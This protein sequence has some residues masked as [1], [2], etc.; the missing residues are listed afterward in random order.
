[1]VDRSSLRL[2]AFVLQAI[3]STFFGLLFHLNKLE[4][5]F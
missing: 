4:F 2:G 3:V 5:G 1:M